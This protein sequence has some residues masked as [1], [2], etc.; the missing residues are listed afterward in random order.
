MA[1]KLTHGSDMACEKNLAERTENLTK[2][3]GGW[4][5]EAFQGGTPSPEADRCQAGVE[6]KVDSRET[7]VHEVRLA[8]NVQGRR[9]LGAWKVLVNSLDIFPLTWEIRENW[10]GGEIDIYLEFL[11]CTSKQL[12]P[13]TDPPGINLW[14]MKILNSVISCFSCA[15]K[16]AETMAQKCGRK[17]TME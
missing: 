14:G 16:E 13:R 12:F 17:G 3:R 8:S 1:N 5:G 15:I 2:S 4:S 6:V 9:S 10:A 11:L 7:G